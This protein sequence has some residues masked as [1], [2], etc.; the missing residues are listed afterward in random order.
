MPHRPF[1]PLWRSLTFRIVLIVMLFAASLAAALHISLQNSLAW[2]L[3]S[4]IAQDLK[5]L[6]DDAHL[7]SDAGLEELL[8]GGGSDN[9]IKARIARAKTA[10]QIDNFMRQR[11]L[12]WLLYA[13]DKLFFRSPDLAPQQIPSSWR[14][15]QL[16]EPIP[17]SFAQ[18]QLF[19]YRFTFDP[20]N[21]EIILIKDRNEYD[22][23]LSHLDHTKR[24]IAL[25][26]LLSTLLLFVVLQRV[27]RKPV[28]AIIHDLNRGRRPDYVG[29][30]EFQ[31]LAEHISG[32]IRNL[33]DKTFEAESANQAKSAF[34]AKMSHEIRT[35]LNAI[36]GMGE[37]LADSPL[38]E[39]QRRHLTVLNNASD[40][41]MALINDLL[42]LSKIEAGQ[43][44]LAEEPFELPPLLTSVLS[45]FETSCQEKGLLLDISINPTTPQWVVGDAQRLRQVL[46]NLLGNAVKFTTKGYVRLKVAPWE[47]SQIFFEVSDSGIGITEQELTRI[48]LPFRQADDS[49]TRRFGGTGLGLSISRH[50]VEAMG[51]AME[52]QSTP[53]R[54]SRFHFVLPLRPTSRVVIEPRQDQY[55]PSTDEP[56]APL[57]RPVDI[58]LA[59]DSK[60]NRLL[61]QAFLKSSR[62]RLT[63]AEDGAQALTLMKARP[64]DLVLMDIQ[65]PMMDGVTATKE[66]R[67]WEALNRSTSTPIIAL[68]AHAMK[69]DAERSIAA[70]CDRH[71]T[72]PISKKQLLN[73]LD[74]HVASQY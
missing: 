3:Q 71:L 41:L 62:Y 69:E 31:F 19:L 15:V 14:S 30:Y 51:G 36:L 13:E 42:D 25:L 57:D 32:I 46:L 18:R 47:E 45:L 23:L 24:I 10:G 21:W 50:L 33:Q 67:A 22:A 35:P 68:T 9:P 17:I 1:K 6:A 44:T 74:H 40:G 12:M 49:I 60:D 11:S 8:R 54:G 72:K 43:L 37:L 59:D 4:N 48:F 65:M 5:R 61:I 38:N 58:L 34:L 7:I 52:V 20:W 66:F 53:G 63:L 70:G 29:I 2:Y 64:F 26:L 55:S 16:E 27:I 39:E 28:N 56:A 73:A